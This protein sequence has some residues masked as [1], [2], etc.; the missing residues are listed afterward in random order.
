[1]RVDSEPALIYQVWLSHLAPAM[2]SAELGA[3]VNVL[4]VFRELEQ[5]LQPRALQESLD[6]TLAQLR[7]Y[8]PDGDWKWGRLHQIEF[9]HPLGRR[10]WNRGP[11]PRPGEA[12]TV[13][14]TSGARFRQTNGASFRMIVD[15][16]NWDRSVMTNVPGESGVPSSKHYDDL[17]ESWNHGV[18]HPMA[19][20]RAY[21]EAS[22][23]ERMSLKRQ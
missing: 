4:A 13:N 19:F 8:F 17:I 3:R 9:R 10:A 15:L 21:V 1:M 7:A 6:A 5:K 16:G 2:F 18:Y 11:V 22:T 14:S 20:S 12:H 23:V